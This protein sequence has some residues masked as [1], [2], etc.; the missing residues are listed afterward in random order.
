MSGQGEARLRAALRRWRGRRTRA[1]RRWWPRLTPAQ[2][3]ALLGAAVT[4]VLLLWDQVRQR[5]AK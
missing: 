1:G 4:L 2:V 5:L 3:Q